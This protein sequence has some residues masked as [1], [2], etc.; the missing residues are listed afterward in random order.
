MK[1]G[2]SD[3]SR[4]ETDGH[5]VSIDKNGA[6]EQRRHGSMHETTAP[7]GE[8]HPT[9]APHAADHER[10]DPDFEPAGMPADRPRN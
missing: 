8:Q 9:Q 4:A 7:N 6:V 2:P 10:V 5:D 1:T 3:S